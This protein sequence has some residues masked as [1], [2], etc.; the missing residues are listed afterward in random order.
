MYLT[1]LVDRAGAFGG[2]SVRNEVYISSLGGHNVVRRLLVLPLS[3]VLV[4]CTNPPTGSP[5]AATTTPTASDSASSVDV[6]S[7]PVISD[8]FAV[9]A[10]LH[11]L[12]VRCFGAGSPTLVFEAGTDS[13]GVSSFPSALLRP[14]ADTNM[15]CLYDRLGTGQSDPPNK[16]RRTLN[17]VIAD[18]AAVLG[19]AHV[20]PPYVLVGQSGGGNIAVWYAA[21]HPDEV[22]GLV[23][24]DAGYD[25]PREMAKEFPGAQAWAGSE[26]VDWT[27][28]ARLEWRMKKPIGTFPVLIL[29]ADHYEG[30]PDPASSAWQS[31]SPNAKE[32]VMHG[33][34]DLHTEIPEQVAEQIRSLLDTL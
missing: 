8:S 4:A 16:A 10:D 5:S 3:V 23:L 20:G 7:H 32:V 22:A 12:A 18:T 19:A 30:H 13:S 14:L 29:S 6:L 15:V 17:D 31:L 24:I 11:E 27:N 33:G 34:H 26:H 28:A 9:G 25:N 1:P 2:E 21:Q